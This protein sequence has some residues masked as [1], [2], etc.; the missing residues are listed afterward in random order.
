MDSD[1]TKRMS[2]QALV[3]SGLLAALVT[4]ATLFF[5]L[6]LPITQG[7]VHLGDTLIL[8]SAMLLGPLAAPIGGIGSALADLLS[9]YG[10]YVLPTLC[11]KALVGFLAGFRLRIDDRHAL[12]RCALTFTVAELVMVLGYAVFEGFAFDVKTAL[13]DV[14]PNLGQALASV[15]L[16][17]A[18]L[19]L[20]RRLPANRRKGL[21]DSGRG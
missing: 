5:K 21:G 1:M 19:P 4:L 14:L 11:V 15:V 18:L 2:T 13:A 10:I 3:L 8:L 17:C 7:Y 20:A 6:P 9:G 12:L 16:A